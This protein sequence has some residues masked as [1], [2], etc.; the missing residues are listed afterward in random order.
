MMFKKRTMYFLT[1]ILISVLNF[2]CTKEKV[3]LTPLDPD[4]TDTVSFSSQIAPMI[5]NNCVSCHDSG[6]STGYTLTNHTNISSNA[7][8]ML[9]AM[10]ESGGMQLMPEGG[11]ALHDT[12]IQQFSCWV[13]Q[14]KL[15]N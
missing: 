12:L 15:N 6:N 13:N 10:Q 14:G 4:C 7:T 9:N 2:S 8:A 5:S 1:L 11:P 3:P